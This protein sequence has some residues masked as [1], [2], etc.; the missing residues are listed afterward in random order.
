MKKTVGITLLELV[1][2]LKKK[3]FLLGLL[4]VLVMGGGMAY[5]AYMFPDS[6]GVHNVI[7][8]YGNFSSILIMFLAAKSLG[9]EFDLKT[10]TFVF[11]SRSSRIQIATAKILSIALAN[12]VIGLFGG[13][14]YDIAWILCKQPWTAAMLLGTIGKEIFIYMVYG[15]AVG[16]TA[17]MVTCFLNTT[18]TPFIYLMVLFWVMPGI[19]QMVGQKIA[20]LGKVMD[21]VV[22]CLADQFLMY[23]DW[24]VKNIA[25]FVLTG[26]AFSITGMVVLQK[27]DL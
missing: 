16:A 9:E 20:V 14:L 26:I 23:Q 15:F 25:V 5:G 19:L 12:M 1:K 21:Y 7:A 24:G 11:T 13:I 17:V 6:F 4:M 8:F 27:K 3:E 22:F 2:S 18:I 10:A